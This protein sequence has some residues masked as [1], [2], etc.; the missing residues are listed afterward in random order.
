MKILFCTDGSKISFNAIKNFMQYSKQFTADIICVAD[1]HFYSLYKENPTQNYQET[2]EE[3]SDKIL[4]EAQE[5][6]LSGG[7]IVDKI[8]KGYGNV[9][10]EIMKQTQKQEYSLIVM[11]SNG[12]KGFRSWLGSV[13]RAVINTSLKNIFISKNETCDKK[14]LFT[15]DGSEYSDYVIQKALEMLDLTECLVYLI[16]V[17]KDLNNLPIELKTNSHWFNKIIE[18]QKQEKEQILKRISEIFNSKNIQ[19]KREFSLI[20]EPAEKILEINNDIDFDLIIMGSHSK[21]ALQRMLLG[22]TSMRVLER[23]KKSVM[24]IYP[25]T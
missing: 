12:K 1:W 20:G 24:I 21:N 7:N 4:S 19:I 11:G 3:L 17:E 2:Y 15:T 18:Q 13:S 16:Y 22:S 25:K 9:S 8:I 6:I 23:A 5:Y 10:E 14:V